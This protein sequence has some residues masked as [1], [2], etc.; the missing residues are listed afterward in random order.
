LDPIKTFHVN[1]QREVDNAET[2]S[3]YYLQCLSD[4]AET[5][6][7]YCIILTLSERH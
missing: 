2:C 7:E 4:N 3:E 6:L 5:C 1:L